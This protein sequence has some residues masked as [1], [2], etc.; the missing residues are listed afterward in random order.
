MRPSSNPLQPQPGPAV[1]DPDGRRLPDALRASVERSAIV[2]AAEFDLLESG[3]SEAGLA[4]LVDAAVLHIAVGTP[5]P[6]AGQLAAAVGGSGLPID[7]VGDLAPDRVAVLVD[8]DPSAAERLAADVRRV[9]EDAVDARPI[10]IGVGVGRSADGPGAVR[11]RA[12]DAL[13]QAR[14][15]SAGDVVVLGTA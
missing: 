1:A 15:S 11:A 3:W 9:V 5:V 7:V 14:Q 8:V 2:A 4:G 6:D 10:W 12:A 13:D